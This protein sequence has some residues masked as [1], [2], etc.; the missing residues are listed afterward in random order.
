M[1]VKFDT[2]TVVNAERNDDS[3]LF[4]LNRSNPAGNIN[5][6]VTDGSG[7]RIVITIPLTHCPIDL[8]NFAE[9]L[10]ILKNPDFRRLVARG[11]I[12]LVDNDQAQK[13]ITEDP[14]GIKET[15]RIYGS[16]EEGVDPYIESG[17][18]D[19][20]IRVENRN[21]VVRES[22]NPFIQ[23]VVLRSSEEDADDL[24]SEVE[25]KLHTLHNEDIQYIADNARS[26]ELKEWAS[27]QM[28]S[29]D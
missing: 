21:R 9:K 18:N 24:I 26:A 27:G 14:R 12:T 29:A 28:D 16:I 1:K 2:T 13:F 10:L 4:V 3:R 15:K 22:E 5:F 6:N 25:S 23:N 11:F 8:S 19:N 20:E 17:I 7:G